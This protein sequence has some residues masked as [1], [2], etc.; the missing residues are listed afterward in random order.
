MTLMPQ[1]TLPGK[2]L[3]RKVFG[4]E[5]HLFRISEDTVLAVVFRVLELGMNS[6][7]DI[8]SK[9]V[10]HSDEHVQSNAER[11]ASQKFGKIYRSR[12]PPP[13]SLPAEFL[14]RLRLLGL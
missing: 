5:F 6:N 12:Q 4:G 7:V 2:S 14:E 9:S 10:R 1:R 13:S 11:S 8:P 3:G